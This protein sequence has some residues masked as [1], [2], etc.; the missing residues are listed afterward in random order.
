LQALSKIPPALGAVLIAGDGPL[1][2]PLQT[3][4]AALDGCGRVRFLGLVA[5]VTSVFH[6]A[7]IFLFP[8]LSES[9]GCALV[10]AM[11]CSLPAIALRP[12]GGRVQTANEEILTHEVSG[13]LV[14]RTEPDEWAQAVD[15]L[16][17][18]AALRRRLGQAARRTAVAR[19]DW[20]AVRGRFADLIESLVPVRP[21]ASRAKLVGPAAGARAT[22][23]L[24]SAV[25]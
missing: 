21:S 2:K 22:T 4:A 16:V 7:D 14:D 18:D 24:G 3:Q 19:Y 23:K 1:E 10:Q 20:S 25:R 13:L 5:D 17:E 6:A 8:S 11:A 9:F 12:D 15:R